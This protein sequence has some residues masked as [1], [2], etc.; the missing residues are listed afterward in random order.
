MK[1]T[2]QILGFMDKIST[3]L[4]QGQAVNGTVIKYISNSIDNSLFL[5]Y[6]FLPHF[7]RCRYA[8]CFGALFPDII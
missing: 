7:S 1:R 4:R 5:K 8:E 2:I 3:K 6:C